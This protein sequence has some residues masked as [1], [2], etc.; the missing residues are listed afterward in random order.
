MLSSND[1]N[2]SEKGFFFFLNER[3]NYLYHIY[4]ALGVINHLN[5]I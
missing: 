5:I 4:I 1:A 2:S 3:G